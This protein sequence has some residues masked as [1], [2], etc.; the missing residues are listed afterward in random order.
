M[1]RVSTRNNADIQGPLSNGTDRDAGIEE[2]NARARRPWI[3]KDKH[4]AM[5]SA[6]TVRQEEGWNSSIMHRLQ[7]TEQ[8]HY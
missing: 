6:R 7:R 3:R 2:T 5:G 8:S 4:I 1:H